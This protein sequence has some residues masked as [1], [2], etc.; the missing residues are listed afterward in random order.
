MAEYGWTD[1]HYANAFLPG[2]RPTQDN[3]GTWAIGL[4][5]GPD[6]TLCV[7][8]CATREDATKFASPRGNSVT[9]AITKAR[10]LL[11][12]REKRHVFSHIIL[13]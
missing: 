1:I 5:T 4:Y 12:G 11:E 8:E 10:I 3:E 2:D 6:R 7:R 13:G 9:E